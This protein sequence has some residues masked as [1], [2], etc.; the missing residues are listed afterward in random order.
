MAA[1]PGEP[2]ARRCV[3]RRSRR[4]GLRAPVKPCAN[5]NAGQSK[6][7]VAGVRRDAYRKRGRK[8]GVCSLAVLEV[9]W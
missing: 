1:G 2:G 9:D 8:T 6:K 3:P 4:S 5:T 7:A